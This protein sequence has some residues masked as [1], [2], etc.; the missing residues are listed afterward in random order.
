MINNS[1]QPTEPQGQVLLTVDA[2][3]LRQFCEL[4]DAP[5][6][7]NEGLARLMALTPPWSKKAGIEG[8]DE[9]K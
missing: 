6:K 9:A 1:H 4:L 2:E 8:V 3:A 5:I 7:H